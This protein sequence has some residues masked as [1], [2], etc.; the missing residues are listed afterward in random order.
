[1]STLAMNCVRCGDGFEMTSD[2]MTAI[3][4]MTKVWDTE[5]KKTCPPKTPHSV[6]AGT[7]GIERL[8]DGRERCSHCGGDPWSDACQRSHR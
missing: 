1:M 7:L 2:D 3:L 4:A 6:I 5:H 8:V